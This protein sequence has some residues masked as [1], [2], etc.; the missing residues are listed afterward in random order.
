MREGTKEIGMWGTII[1]KLTELLN[2]RIVWK[3]SGYIYFLLRAPK[4]VAK[5]H[6]Q[7]PSEALSECMNHSESWNWL[8]PS[9]K[10]YSQTLWYVHLSRLIIHT[11]STDI[12]NTGLKI[13][14]V[15][16][17]HSLELF[18]FSARTLSH[19]WRQRQRPLFCPAA[20]TLTLGGCKA[21]P[22][23]MMMHALAFSLPLYFPCRVEEVWPS[24]EM[25]S[26]LSLPRPRPPLLHPI[27][28]EVLVG[29]FWSR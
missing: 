8:K 6:E 2:G 14:A 12:S 16:S 22:E 15:R 7:R 19:R 29:I 24:N 25:E 4:A 5:K 23:R 3:E 18:A 1:Q 27:A 10:I 20:F 13:Y 9:S 21:T 11:N 28:E 26:S 17:Q